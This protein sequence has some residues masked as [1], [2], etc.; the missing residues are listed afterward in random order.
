MS[1]QQQIQREID[2]EARIDKKIENFKKRFLKFKSNRKYIITET[3]KES[4]IIIIFDRENMSSYNV[5]YNNEKDEQLKECETN[6]RYTMI[7]LK[8]K[9]PRDTKSNTIGDIINIPK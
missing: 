1:L 7:F 8:N 9:N 6:P 4:H 5:F 2:E 3:R